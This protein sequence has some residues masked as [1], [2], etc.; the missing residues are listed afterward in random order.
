MEMTDAT[1]SS[2]A[3]NTVDLGLPKQPHNNKKCTWGIIHQ[4]HLVI[5]LKYIS[6]SLLAEHTVM[7]AE[8][9]VANMNMEE[10]DSFP[11]HYPPQ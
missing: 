7:L 4:I 2:G 1:T 11:Q 10:P 8:H 9:T 5:P 6:L 3:L